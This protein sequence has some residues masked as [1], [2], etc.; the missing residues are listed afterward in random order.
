VKIIMN[1][2]FVIIVAISMLL[3]E[4]I[5]ECVCCYNRGHLNAVE[6]KYL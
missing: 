6:G 2:F 1:V 3:R 5:Y 4:Y